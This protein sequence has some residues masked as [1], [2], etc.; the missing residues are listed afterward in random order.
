MA[1]YRKWPFYV[2]FV[3]SL[4]GFVFAMLSSLDYAKHLDRQLHDVHCSLIPGAAAAGSAQSACKTAMFSPYA[5]V[6]RDSYWGG[7]PISLPAIGAFAFFAGLSLFLALRATPPPKGT[8]GLFA[9]TGVTPLLVSL[10]MLSISWLK[11]GE[12][13]KTCVGIYLSSAVLAAMSVVGWLGYRKAKALMETEFS[14][15]ER[16]LAM[17]VL[18]PLVTLGAFSLAP[19]LLYASSVPDYSRLVGTCGTLNKP[20]P[21]A[22]LHAAHPGATQPATL[23][24]DPLCPT[25]K[26]FHGKLVAEGIFTKLDASLVLFPLDTPCNWM[27]TESVHPGACLTAKAILCSD[28]DAVGALEWAYANQAEIMTT[29]QRSGEAAVKALL[30][31]ALPAAKGCIDDKKTDRRLAQMLRFA[32]DNKLPVSTPQMFLG[33]QRVCEEDTD[34]GLAYAINKLAPGLNGGKP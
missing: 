11:L 5:A 23:V 4:G 15:D 3:A 29:A 13:C 31:K 14:I 9:L 26:A 2:A 19:G 21:E 7:I 12:F 17:T 33:N 6:F 28:R 27:L 24:V 18:G 34:M 32:V 22:T 8:V 30:V 16:S 25:C 10:L 1:E 20:N